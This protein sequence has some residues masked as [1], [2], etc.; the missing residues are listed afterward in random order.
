MT[1]ARFRKLAL[2]FEGVTEVPHF[3]R[4]AFRTAR[5]I[6]A[7][8]GADGRVNL[9]VEPVDRREALL[10]SFPDAFHHLGGWTRLGY[11]GVDLAEVED[12]LFV[13]LL[14]EA[15]RAALPKP[16]ARAKRREARAKRR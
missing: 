6:F 14:G 3:D 8:L 16:K 11:V 5:K 10:E 9:V 15:Y 2:A 7:T 4:R 13:E 12:G 1:P